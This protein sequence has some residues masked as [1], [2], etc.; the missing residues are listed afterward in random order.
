[1][2][3]DG[4]AIHIYAQCA[5]IAIKIIDESSRWIYRRCWIQD[6]CHLII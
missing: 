4:W 3:Y 5:V 1:M 2:L 6:A